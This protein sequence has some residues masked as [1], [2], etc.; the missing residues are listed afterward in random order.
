M[1]RR[2]LLSDSAE[3]CKDILKHCVGRKEHLNIWQSL[4]Y[5][6]NENKL[7]VLIS[8]RGFLFNVELIKEGNI[9]FKYTE[10]VLNLIN[11]IYKWIKK[12][13]RLSSKT[14]SKQIP[15]FRSPFANKIV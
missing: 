2:L 15:I 6:K 10:R 14:R 13:N 8:L 3:L 12:Y 9:W 5:F 7:I 11:S 4:A 1:F